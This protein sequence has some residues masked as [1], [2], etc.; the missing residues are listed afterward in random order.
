MTKHFAAVLFALVGCAA[1]TDSAF[2]VSGRV[3]DSQVTHVVATSPLTAERVVAEVA[4]DGSFDIAVAPGMTWAMTFANADKTGSD[5]RVGT[6]TSDGLDALAPSAAGSLDFG[7]VS[8]GNGRATPAVS[9]ADL[10]R[11]LGLDDASAA[12]LAR[13][14]D[15]ARRYANP[16]IDND[17]ELDALEG[18][19]VRLEV[20]GQLALAIGDREAT[21]A[22]LVDGLASPSVRFD[23]TMLVA[24]VPPTM[25]MQM[26]TG[27]ITFDMPYY[28]TALGPTTPMIEPGTPIGDPHIFHG[29]LAGVPALGISARGD[30]DAPRG[31]YELAFANGQLTF[32]DVEPPSA[33]TLAAAIDYRV[34]FVHISSTNAAPTAFE[35]DWK[36]MG[37]GG[38]QP[39]PGLAVR[40]DVIVQEHGTR[41]AYAPI[42]AAD[43]STL[44]WRDVAPE[45]GAIQ[46]F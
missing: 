33:A 16:D 46:T 35:I 29:E 42:L 21:V 12:L 22:D 36:Q 3:T 41:H 44:A 25:A 45:L 13:T 9:H 30:H 26:D 1:D 11:A 10:V 17:G 14:D 7:A 18:H 23:N 2:H 43:Q 20:N 28:G 27:T 19:D 32:S 15:L 5:M 6:L 34:P 40:L 4:S 39:A 24:L 37:E 38:W 31:T 8:F